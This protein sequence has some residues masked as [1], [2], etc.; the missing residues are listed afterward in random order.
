MVPVVAA[1]LIVAVVLGM[2][3]LSYATTTYTIAPKL[4]VVT[5]PQD[6]QMREKGIMIL[7]LASP[8]V[9]QQGDIAVDLMSQHKIVVTYNGQ[10]LT[11]SLGSTAAVAV[12]CNVLEK[13]KVRVVDDPKTTAVPQGTWEN[14]KTKLVDVS[15]NFV[16]KL[17]WKS[18]AGVPSMQESVGVLDVYYKGSTTAPTAQAYIADHILVLTAFITIGRTIIYGTDIQD[19]CVLGWA[20]LPTSSLLPDLNPTRVTKPDGTH[21][22][23]WINPLGTFVSCEDAALAQRHTL[24]MPFEQSGV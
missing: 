21:H 15:A 8:G 22:W 6:D 4:E 1:F 3:P 5:I 20:F 17:R 11:W 14:A 18:P 10:I 7:G 12:L 19:I 13:D 23:I 9:T 16:C 24:N 2:T